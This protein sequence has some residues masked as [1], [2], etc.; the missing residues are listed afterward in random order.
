MNDGPALAS[1]FCAPSPR[2]DQAARL[3]RAVLRDHV[4]QLQ[5]RDRRRAEWAAMVVHELRRPLTLIDLAA[6][7]LQESLP[8]AQE[9][10]QERLEQI[11]RGVEE[12]SRTTIDLLDASAIEARAMRVE[13]APVRVVLVVQSAIADMPDLV[14]RCRLR[15]EAGADVQV[16]ADPRR[17]QQVL[18][19]L[20][21][22]AAK[23]GEPAAKIEVDLARYDAEVRVTVSSRGPGIPAHQLLHV[24]DRFARSPQTRKEKPGLGLGLY[25]A[26]GL[27]EAQGGR[28]WAKSAPG[29][30]TQ[31]HFTLP[32]ASIR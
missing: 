12:L 16:T 30:I 31:F 3:E 9:E 5:G 14:E 17:V 21:E 18:G 23:Y 15:V 32:L 20:L 28:I 10:A 2:L 29:I 1:A 13:P 25:I 7:L 22:N 4:E 6:Q 24:F 26:K 19:N 27:I 8:V 11:R